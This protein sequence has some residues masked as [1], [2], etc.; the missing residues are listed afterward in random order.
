MTNDN[1]RTK[2]NAVFFSVIMVLSMVAVGFAAAPAAAAN[3][4]SVTFDDQDLGSDGAV[5]V[6]VDSLSGPSGNNVTAVVTYTSGG[7]TTVAGINTTDVG[8][9]DGT[10]SVD[11]GDAGGFPGTHTAHLFNPSTAPSL[12][13]SGT[14]STSQANQAFASDT[15]AV[16]A[17]RSAGTGDV[18]NGSTVYQGEDDLTF[19]DDDG[20]TV[21]PGALQKT[22][23]SAEGTSLQLPI[24]TDAATGTYAT[25]SGFEVIVQEPRI[26]TS[27]V[28]ISG[29]GSDVSQVGPDA[30]DNLDIVAE[31]N[32]PEAEDLSITVEDPS[33]TDITGEVVPGSTTLS[34][35]DDSTSLDLSGEDAGEY[36]VIFEGNDNLDH[37]EVVEEYTIE[38]TTDDTVQVEVS[39][40]SVTQGENLEYTVSGGTNGQFHTVTID[41]EDFRSDNIDDV[42]RNVG[43][44]SQVGFANS[45]SNN[46]NPSTAD[47]AYAVVEIDGT[48][49]TGSIDAGTLDDA[50]ITLD[51]YEANSSDQV[52]FSGDSIDDTSFDVES[53]EITIESPDNQYTIGSQVDIN[54][55]ATS[56]EAVDVYVR[57]NNEW[58]LLYPDIDV[59]SADEYEQE[60]VVLSSPGLNVNTPGADLLSQAGTY[61]YGV[62]DHS[63][64]NGSTTVETTA[65]SRATS[66]QQSLTTVQGELSAQL[67]TVNGQIN[68]LDNAAD[69]TG[70]AEGQDTIA[71][72]YVDSRGNVAAE[73][74]D[75]DDD[76]TVDVEDNTV[77][78]VGA[79]PNGVSLNEG[80]VTAHFISQS[81]DNTVG[82]GELPTGSASNNVQDLV[83]WVNN[84]VT[85]RSVTGDQARSLIVSETTDDT[86]SDDLMVTQ[87]FRYT[88]SQTTLQSIYPDVAQ[89][90]GINPVAT[91]ETMVV[92]GM[93]NLRPDDNSITV[94][95]LNQDG[96]SLVI[97]STDEWAT[98]GQ[99]NTSVDTSDLEPGTYVV[100]TD[101]GENTDRAE[102]EIVEER[103]T[104]SPEFSV[105]DLNPQD[106]T[107]TQGDAI[108]VSAMIENTGDA[109]GSQ[110]VEFQVGGNT[111][112]SEEVELDAGGSQTVEFTG[113]DTSSLDA[114]DYEHG[115]YTDDDSQT[116]T[117]TV[118]A[119][120][121]GGDDGASD[122]GASDDG[123]SDD[124]ASDDG[125][126]D[127]GAS[128]DGASD[129]GA[130]DDGASDDGS[131][132]GSTDDST[133]GFGALV[134]LVALIAAALLATR[135][136]D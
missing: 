57:S 71:L 26:T 85:Q 90:D 116:A 51:V 29:S 76:G 60:E 113:I 91:G 16:T 132:D 100:E 130:S 19:I 28:Q 68:T 65:F 49:A 40:E 124:G 125:A 36:T 128:D 134:A 118:E 83:D 35:G 110:T 103:D 6:E 47:V 97:S 123:A 73:T 33:G 74:V 135:R 119:P 88:E 122:D 80:T 69:I 81:R 18:Y 53:G 54:G 95:V 98:S 25:S 61:R 14:V 32:F 106:V 52:D 131:G 127:D 22:A 20:S 17:Q 96:D 101:D 84:D 56:A 11:I 126:S 87:S 1:T 30:A 45:T 111:I 31:W 58:R 24:A 62:V 107:V 59:D 41:A 38:F 37:D 70:T 42:F 115:V 64:F 12:S 34:G 99:W 27:E 89:A 8:S 136:R 67:E 93:T 23:G 94:E 112:A 78:N 102:V 82:D 117:L 10:V 13:V 66:T 75:V 9:P 21:T 72:V 129:D 92:E 5:D 77:P 43:D 39:E 121:T 48:T 46:A 114:G 133:P 104:G 4:G 50:S 105:S 63:E 55:T 44:T 109:A 120:D 7:T 2:A 79:N 15:A 86:A 108:D 3:S